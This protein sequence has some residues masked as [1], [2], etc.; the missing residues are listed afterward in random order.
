MNPAN[1][2]RSIQLG[3]GGSDRDGVL[4]R[5]RRHDAFFRVAAQEFEALTVRPVRSLML[6]RRD[7]PLLDRSTIFGRRS[8]FIERAST[9]T[10]KKIELWFSERPAGYPQ[11][12]TVP[13]DES[14]IPSAAIANHGDNFSFS[15]LNVANSF[16]AHGAI[17]LAPGDARHL[18][19]GHLATENLTVTLCQ[20]KGTAKIGLSFEGKPASE[21][22]L[23]PRDLDLI[24]GVLGEAR[25]I[26]SK[27]VSFE[28]SKDRRRELMV[29]NPAWRTEPPIHPTLNGITL[30]LRHPGLGWLTFLLPWNEVKSL[31]E[32]LVKASTPGSQSNSQ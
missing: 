26:M 7:D 6:P 23:T 17:N 3:D 9:A 14:G 2:V 28:P 27:P 15:V 21:L 24:I 16:R 32:W 11:S 25:A 20:D 30:R 4:V 1:L 10:G 5:A 18:P 29:L 19:V 13:R 22:T 31:G 8:E 12:I